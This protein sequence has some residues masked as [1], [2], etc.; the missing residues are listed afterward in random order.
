MRNAQEI[1]AEIRR[2]AREAR[3][4][5]FH[6]SHVSLGVYEVDTLTDDYESR[7][8]YEIVAPITAVAGLLISRTMDESRIRV[9]EQRKYAQVTPNLGK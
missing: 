1:I 8:P 6:P 9:Y 3:A 7:Q 5:G 2:R 4:A